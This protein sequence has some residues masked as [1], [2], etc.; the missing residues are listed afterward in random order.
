MSQNGQTQHRAAHF[1]MNAKG[2]VGKSHHAVLLL[3]AYRA[4]GLPVIGID[5]DATSATFSSFKSLKI[6][7]MDIMEREQ[8]NARVF[9]NIIEEILTG[10]SNFVIDTG[11]SSFVE[12]NR[13]LAKNA[14]PDV[15]TGA[16]KRFVT[17]LIITGGATFNETCLNLKAIADQAPA[18]V[19]IVVW[20]NEHFGPI[21]DG[22]AF[23]DLEIYKLTAPRISAVIRIAD[24]T[25]AEQSTFG[26]DVKQMMRRGYSFEDVKAAPTAEFTVMA[27]SRLYRLQKDIDGKLSAA[28]SF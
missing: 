22:R 12:L 7:R 10:D 8:I 27:K 2:G 25:F 13:Y 26:E 21:A 11:A 24:H 28:F 14:G 20:L 3:Q 15:V 9:D 18:S 5:A 1:F 4:A 6:R 16:G 19:E 23:E 17:N